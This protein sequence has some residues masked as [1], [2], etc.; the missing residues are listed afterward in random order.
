MPPPHTAAAP[1]MPW[2]GEFGSLFDD[3]AIFPPGNA[4][5]ITALA[6]HWEHR[7]AWYGPMVGTFVCDG[8]RGS[9]LIGQLDA[10]GPVL[11]LSLVIGQDLESL[12][13]DVTRVRAHPRVRLVAVEMPVGHVDPAATGALLQKVATTVPRTATVYAEV[14]LGPGAHQSIQAV[15]EAGFRIKFR[16]GGT[17]AD[18]FPDE[19]TLAKGLVRA[20]RLRVPFKLTAGLHHA[21]RHTDPG[22]GFEHH[23][24]LNVM[25][26]VAAAH[27]GADEETVTSLL[28]C[29]E[30]DSVARSCTPARRVTA[31]AWFTS[32]GTCSIDEPLAD[33]VDLRL[34]ERH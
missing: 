7:A 1:R 16:T 26:A 29:R 4:P 25:A 14:V 6:R 3:A 34:V 10:G 13:T 27:E 17:R 28:A 18:A 2:I 22:T 23:G 32:F 21:V 5:V 30:P 20:V 12:A 31:R 15:A 9:E 19:S 11:D 8:R 33:L 24:F